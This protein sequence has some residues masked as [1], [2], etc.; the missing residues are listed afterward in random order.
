MRKLSNPIADIQ[1]VPSIEANTD[2]KNDEISEDR[3]QIVATTITKT[4]NCYQLLRI[5]TL[6]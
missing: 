3:K 4:T 5:T 1:S 6:T 2:S